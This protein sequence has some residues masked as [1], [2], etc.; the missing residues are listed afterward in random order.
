[1]KNIIVLVLKVVVMA[2]W[3]GIF[4]VIGVAL[5]VFLLKYLV[6]NIKIYTSD[7]NQTSDVIEIS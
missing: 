5:L 2:D 1:V 4:V 7:L 6:G 3:T